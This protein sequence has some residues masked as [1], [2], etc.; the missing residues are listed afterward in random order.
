[1]VTDK[2]VA[3]KAALVAFAGTVTVAGTVTAALLLDRLILRPPLG[4]AALSVTVQ[5]SVP[6][7]VMDALLQESALSAA[8]TPV[9][10]VPVPLRAITAVPLAGELLVMVSCPVAAPAAAGLNRTLKLEVPPA[11]MVTG[12]V[13]VPTTEKDSPVRLSWVIWTG[14]EFPLTRENVASSVWPTD[15]SPKATGF[16]EITRVPVLP[17]LRTLVPQPDRARNR[18]QANIVAR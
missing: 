6:D 2:T 4:A 10:A 1:M 8:E 11:G 13:L 14:V 16:G 3:V 17:P 7:P 5:A 9:A 15:T 18:T 12:R